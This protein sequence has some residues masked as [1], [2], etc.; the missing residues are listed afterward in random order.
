MNPQ[1]IE[2]ALTRLRYLR[3]DYDLAGYGDDLVK[4]VEENPESTDGEGMLRVVRVVRSLLHAIEKDGIEVTDDPDYD[5]P[6]DVDYGRPSAQEE[7]ER[8]WLEQRDL[9]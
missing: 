2:D 7:A 5:G 6:G 9:R 3:N 4:R 8:M 1:A